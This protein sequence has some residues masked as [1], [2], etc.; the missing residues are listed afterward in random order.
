MHMIFRRIVL[1]VCI[2]LPTL[3]EAQEDYIF[4]K[5]GTR[6]FNK[7]GLVFNC[8]RSLNK[9]RS[10]PVAMQVCECQV[11]AIDGYFTRAQY[12]KYTKNNVTDLPAMITQD[13]VLNNRIQ[14]CFT[15]TGRT[16]LM[17]AER[18][19][20]GY[21]ADCIESVKASTN[22]TLDSVRLK[23]FC[24][25]QVELIKV[26]Q[27]SDAELQTINDPNSLLFFELIHNCGSPYASKEFSGNEW[28]ASAARDVRGPAA[29]TISILD[30]GG[31]SF[32]KLKIGS[33]V[34]VWLLDTGASELL[35]TKE[36]EDLLKKENILLQENYLGTEEFEMANG[37]VEPCRRYRVNN[38]RIGKFYLDNIIVSVSEKAK[39]LLVGRSL[40]NKFS[41]WTLDNRTKTLVL[42]K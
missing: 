19:S 30:V 6:M 12:R 31:M 27:L 1:A 32:V 37:Q 35:I 40:L 39:R 10:D 4:S 8:L 21:I 7:R 26:K 41:H 42:S 14:A 2:I 28:T 11:N 3:L 13:T 33:Q 24:G 5:D 36:M 16:V 18:S 34:L 9:D 29:D 38:V 17:S 22:K 20:Q 25:C 23:N 15:A